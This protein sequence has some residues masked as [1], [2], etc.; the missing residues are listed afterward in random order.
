MVALAQTF[1]HDLDLLGAIAVGDEHGIAGVDDDQVVDTNR[2]DHARIGLD[3][4]V[5]AFDNDGVTLHAIAGGI[6]FVADIAD[7]L[8]RADVAPV[9]L[10]RHDRDASRTLHDC[11]IDRDVGLGHEG[12]A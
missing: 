9:E 12:F 1:D 2:C 3:V 8:P 10:R 11:V 7:R 4:A 5:A 6:G